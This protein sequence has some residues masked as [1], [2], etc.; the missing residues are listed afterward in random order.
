MYR[1]LLL[2][3]SLYTINTVQKNLSYSTSFVSKI[4]KSGASGWR[5]EEQRGRLAGE[6]GGRKIPVLFGRCSDFSRGTGGFEIFLTRA[7]TEGH[8]T[9][10]HTHTHA[11]ARA[12][13][14]HGCPQARTAR[15][16][17]REAGSRRP[18][19][20]FPVSAGG[21]HWRDADP[22]SDGR[23]D[24]LKPRGQTGYLDACERWGVPG[25]P[26]PWPVRTCPPGRRGGAWLEMGRNRK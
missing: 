24:R 23:R 21:G 11:R 10:T 19:P 3:K 6:G 4:S 20:A 18:F 17:S 9:H 7:H 22:A 15:W 14:R 5:Q 26:P 1:I 2:K 12:R 25:S 8:T 13:M 16:G